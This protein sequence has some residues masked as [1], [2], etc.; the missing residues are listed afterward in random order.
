MRR[1]GGS[2]SLGAGP[3]NRFV[4]RTNTEQKGVRARED[5]GLEWEVR[6]RRKRS[7]H[8]PSAQDE[9]EFIRLHEIGEYD[10]STET[11]KTFTDAESFR[12]KVGRR[13]TGTRT[14]QA[15]QPTCTA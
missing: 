3:K 4:G 10:R 1:I 13:N 15:L 7:E 5:A 2:L 8:Q 9:N 14:L 11:S 12:R 6:V